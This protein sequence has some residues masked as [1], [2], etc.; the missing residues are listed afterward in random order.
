MKTKLC[1]TG[2]KKIKLMNKLKNKV[3]VVTGG[4]GLL[5]RQIIN[6]IVNN[7]GIAVNLDVNSSEVDDFIECDITNN[8][9]VD[10]A[11][12]KIIKKYNKIDG[13]V[14]NAYPRTSD[15]SN[16]FENIKY[17]SWKNNIE[18]QLN[19]HF[20]ITQKII[21]FMKVNN[22]GSIVNMTSIY[23]MIG[24][25]FS[26]YESTEMTMPAAYSAI[27]GGLLNFTKY[28]ASY[29]GKY[30]IRVNSV[31]PGGIFNNQNEK[32]VKNYSKNTLG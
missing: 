29:F 32:F 15:W 5:G 8:N 3:I 16:K 25:D 6:S 13:L 22:S 4:S 9:S 20:Y 18:M 27:K 23:G 1:H 31:S 21:N 12:E 24:P 10:I 28:L 30:N 17:E 7:G 26:I 2:F 11:F 19:S 14:N